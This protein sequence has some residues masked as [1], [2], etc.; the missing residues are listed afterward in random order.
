MSVAIVTDSTSDLAPEQAKALQVEIIPIWVIWNGRRMRDGVDI[1]R[2]TFYARLRT[3]KEL[4]TTEPPSPEEC[5]AVFARLV[6]S[7]HEVVAPFL[8]RTLSKTYENAA[9]A[10]ERFRGKV[11]VVDTQTFSGGLMMH[12]TAAVE[13]ARQGVPAREI[14]QRLEAARGSQRCH[15]VMPDVTYLGRSGRL[16]KAIVALG[17]LMKVS[18]VLRLHDGVI[19][20]AAQ[21]RSFDRSQEMLID[22]AVR[23]LERVEATRF[24]IGDVDAPAAGE[25]LETALRNKLPRPPAGIVRYE[26]GPSVGVHGGPGSLA[27]YSMTFAP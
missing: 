26:A 18:P 24:A 12:V 8:S 10:A 7:G 3:E 5:A 20:L 9:A 25:A 15:F 16:N 19:D 14:V 17:T 6:E 21:S 4:P 27:I 11:H 23:H 1:E 2:S 13:W 22:L